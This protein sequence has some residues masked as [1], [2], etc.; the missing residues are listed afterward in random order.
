MQ[1]IRPERTY[2]SLKKTTNGK[3][4]AFD[5]RIIEPA[6]VVVVDTVDSDAESDTD[7]GE[8]ASLASDEGKTAFFDESKRSDSTP[9][10][11]Q[12]PPPPPPPHTSRAM[13][14]LVEEFAWEV[15]HY[16]PYSPDLAATDFHLFRSLQI[17]LVGQMLTS[18]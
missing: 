11:C 18:R 16:P 13:E 1:K 15:M 7:E 2:K 12:T 6:E 17:H 9:R 10:Q 4:S 8:E 3:R 14:N 5:T